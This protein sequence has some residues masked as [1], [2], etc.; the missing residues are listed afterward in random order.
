MQ[1]ETPQKVYIVE[2]EFLGQISV[3]ELLCRMIS[4]HQAPT[5]SH[6][7]EES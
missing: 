6:R 7:E 2:R 4:E 3:E 5:D 1:Q